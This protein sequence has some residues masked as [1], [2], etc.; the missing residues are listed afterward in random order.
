MR[1]LHIG[2]KPAFPLLDGGC[3]AIK[4][5]LDAL[6]DGK[7]QYLHHFTLSTFKHP[8]C[9]TNY[10]A[11]YQ[12]KMSISSG[13]I[14]TKVSLLGAL[15]HLVKNKSYNVERFFDEEV[16]KQLAAIL[17]VE[18]FDFIILESIYL[19]PYIEVFRTSSAKVILR[20]H[21]IEH[22]I[23]RNLSINSKNLLK[24]KYFE[25]LAN[26]LEVFEKEVIGEVDG[27]LAISEEDQ[28]E[29][30]T[31]KNVLN[32]PLITLPTALEITSEIVDYGLNDYYFLGAMDWLPNSEGIEWLQREICEH[33]N[34]IP[35]TIHVA[36]KQLDKSAFSSTNYFV[37]H[38][39]VEDAFKFIQQ[40]GIC[41]IPLFSGSGVKIK[42]LENMALGKPIITTSEG[43][44]GVAVNHGKEVWIADTP[45]TFYEA[46]MRLSEDQKLREELGTNAQKFI[47][48]NYE[49]K[50]I[51]N[52]LRG[53]LN[54]L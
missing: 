9:L 47:R 40:Y 41:L 35:A 3:I 53:F 43:V 36:G 30:S 31:W 25:V 15:Q 19:L 52:Q 6:L 49:L 4:S 11:S 37:N 2:N 24:R 51:S 7:P 45:Q 16:A 39:E 21:N 38:G 1:I 29:I 44:R 42:L 5:M 23:W 10:P 13:F 50:T 28:I 34:D 18:K 32:T 46:M 22:Q 12:N 54:G 17:R 14:N 26:Q 20:A 33:Y 8:F 27:I 48:D